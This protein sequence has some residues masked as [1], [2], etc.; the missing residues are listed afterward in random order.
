LLGINERSSPWSCEG[1]MPSVGE[2]QGREAEVGGCVGKHPHRSRR[3]GEWNR[4]CSSGKL[5]NGIT[6]EM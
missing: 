1:S 2:C 6:F 3:R 5:E 4:G